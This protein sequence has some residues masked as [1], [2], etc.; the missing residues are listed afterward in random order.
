MCAIQLVVY[1]TFIT[2][3][4]ITF[5]YFIRQLHLQWPMVH[6]QSHSSSP[7]ASLKRWVFKSFLK[8]S[9]FVSVCDINFSIEL[10]Y[11][12]GHNAS[13]YMK[14]TR[15][16]KQRKKKEN[17]LYRRNDCW[18]TCSVEVDKSNTKMDDWADKKNYIFLAA[19][20]TIWRPSWI[21]YSPIVCH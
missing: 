17:C 21:D 8:V 15:E 2:L 7:N 18:M 19:I 12:H 6:K 14:E 16:K 20:L 1:I 9:V 11:T 13:A 3:H 10:I 5:R 4:Y